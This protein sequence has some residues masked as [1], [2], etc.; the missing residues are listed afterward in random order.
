MTSRKRRAFSKDFKADAVRLV[1]E[2]GKTIGEVTQQFD[3]TESALREWV[4]RAEADAGKGPPEALT[5]SERAELVEL[6]KR[7][8]R[9]EM[10][11]DILKKATAFFAREN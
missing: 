8:K 11:R 4:R 2:G 6:R 3:L 1:Q 10:E 9:A 5:T 7:L